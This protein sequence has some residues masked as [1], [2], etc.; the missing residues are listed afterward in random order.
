MDQEGVQRLGRGR[1]ARLGDHV[2]GDDLAPALVGLA[3]AGVVLARYTGSASAA[4]SAP[5]TRRNASP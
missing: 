4:G 1:G 3:V 5:D 2:G